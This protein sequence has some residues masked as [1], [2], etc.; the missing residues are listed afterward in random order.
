MSGASAVECLL[1]VAGEPLTLGDIARA[2]E[3]DE[4]A[5]RQAVEDVG[6]RLAVS[7]SGL[8]VVFI[9]GGYQLAT[10]PEYAEC[11]GRL[12]TRAAPKL[13]RAALETLAIVAYRQPITQPEIEAVRGVSVDSVVKTL[14]DRRL[15]A[16]VGRRQ[17]PGRPIL[18][19]T[20][21]DF[22]HYFA[23]ADLNELPPLDADVPEPPSP[24]AAS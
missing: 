22:L 18:Y 5:A 12:L 23:I 10:R 14:V 1:F 2:L 6:R 16:E 21:P 20:T 19:G 15:V 8:Q 7:G 11:V 13:S 24:V 17:A 9:A 4:A 3:C